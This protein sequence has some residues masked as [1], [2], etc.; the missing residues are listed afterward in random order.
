MIYL[1]HFLKYLRLRT[2]EAKGSDINI[3]PPVPL[4]RACHNIW[5]RHH[6]IVKNIIFCFEFYNLY[7]FY[8]PPHH[9]HWDSRHTH[10]TSKK[11]KYFNLD[12]FFLDCKCWGYPWLVNTLIIAALVLVSKLARAVFLVWPVLTVLGSVTISAGLCK[13]KVILT[14]LTG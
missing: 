13:R 6:L 4:L 8:I 1:K 5:L 10:H 3:D 2:L 12:M 14:F 7:L 11:D 9:H